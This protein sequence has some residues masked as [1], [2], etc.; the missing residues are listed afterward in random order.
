MRNNHTQ[1]K[2]AF[3]L[4]AL[5][6]LQLGMFSQKIAGIKNPKNPAK[7][8][9]NSDQAFA[10]MP[11]EV[12][13]GLSIDGD[14]IYMI[15]SDYLW[16]DEFF[17]S[18]KDGIAIDLMSK[19]MFECGKQNKLAS[20]WLHE[21][22]LIKPV[23]KKQLLENVVSKDGNLWIIY[24]GQ[25][26]P[27]LRGTELEAV[28][29]LLQKSCLCET[30]YFYSL[31]SYKWKMLDVGMMKE[32][33][34]Y[35]DKI[36]Q[37]FVSADSSMFNHKT[38]RFEFLFEKDKYDYSAEDLKPL[39]DSLRLTDYNIETINIKAYSSVEGSEQ[40]NV[41]LQEKRAQS[42]VK[43]LQAYQTPQ[44][45]TTISAEENWADFYEQID[46]TSFAHYAGL[47]KEQI[48]DSLR[49]DKIEELLKD[50]L[51]KERKAVLELELSRKD[52]LFLS[53]PDLLLKQLNVALASGDY[54]KADLIQNAMYHQIV[55]G[56]F[57]AVF[58]DSVK[59]DEK[60]EIWQMQNTQLIFSSMQDNVNI[61]SL[62]QIYEEL[63]RQVPGQK[64]I[65]YN[66][67]ALALN[68][69]LRKAD[70]ASCKQLESDIKALVNYGVDKKILTKMLINLNMKM[71]EKF[72][73]ERDY[74]S[75]DKAM[76]FI[77][78]NQKYADLSDSDLQ[79]VAQ[80]FVIYGN[81]KSAVKLVES[82]VYGNNAS[83]ELIFY[84]LGLTITE[85]YN[86]RSPRYKKVLN[87]AYEKNPERFCQIFSSPVK[88]GVS[89]QLL[90]HKNL[91]TVY[92]K[93]CNDTH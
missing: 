40:R 91:K 69:S 25:V 45:E 41:D 16:F 59:L 44:I 20:N 67:C 12:S 60:K 79:N 93:R 64:E 48:K 39:Y 55:N 31:P 82:R 80:F 27:D 75:K 42:I 24:I 78:A 43:A 19:S 92:C 1:V 38:M 68:R 47:S 2:Q 15:L 65:K 81:L 90:R 33:I 14:K 18:S 87:K 66:L 58:A 57:P 30:I 51:A 72:M 49:N 89:F 23:Y 9:K 56:A 21:G 22:T 5:M 13:F 32:K 74:R 8:C 77:I 35:K 84:Y 10:M 36:G 26:P 54:K 86:V 83:E 7:S 11:S 3:L 29:L 70:V 63:D 73:F 88:G 76:K 50:I 62:L 37:A 6:F 4:I 46:S 34:V 52:S 71:G 53:N 85:E 61:D 17:K 28:M